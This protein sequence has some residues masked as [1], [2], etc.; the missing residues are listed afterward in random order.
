M[1]ELDLLDSWRRQLLFL[2]R[3]VAVWL[4]VASVVV[5]P[6]GLGAAVAWVN[7]C[8]VDCPCDDGHAS[9]EADHANEGNRDG[10]HQGARES[11][12][13]DEGQGDEDCPEDCPD[14]DCGLGVLVAVVPLTMPGVPAPRASL[15]AP[16][17]RDAPV[18]GTFFNVYRPPRSST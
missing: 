16:T 15:V 18:Q 11:D 13:K 5:G 8:G 14:C 10:Q 9:A 12:Q 6:L 3:V 4:L 17:L 1:L 7:N 2:W